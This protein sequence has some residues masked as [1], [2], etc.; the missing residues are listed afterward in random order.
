MFIFNPAPRV[1]RQSLWVHLYAKQ[2][3]LDKLHLMSPC[4]RQL[5]YLQRKQRAC[6]NINGAVK[7]C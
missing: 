5:V 1:T 2:E 3:L 7:P 4:V 6:R